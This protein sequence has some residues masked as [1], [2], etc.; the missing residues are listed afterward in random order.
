MPASTAELPLP[1]ESALLVVDS[2]E[3]RQLAGS[4]YNQRRAECERAAALLGIESLRDLEGIPAPARLPSPLDGRAR[5]VVTENERVR[6]GTQGL[7]APDFGRLMNE[8]HASL[9]ADFD[10]STPTLDALAAVLQAD[11]D[12]FGAKLT[13]AG[14]GGACV[15]LVRRDRT[16]AV[17]SRV[18]SSFGKVHADSAVLLEG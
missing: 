14:F 7:S 11:P 10:V 9:S 6:R 15:A 2:G 8:S 3:S 17:A 4:G 18:M 16:H 12:T 13:G 5:H 1:P